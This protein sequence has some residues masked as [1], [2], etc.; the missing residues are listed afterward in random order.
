MQPPIRSGA[1][2]RRKVSRKAGDQL[3]TK[4]VDNFV[5]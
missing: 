4:L 1:A 2:S 3:S 5:D